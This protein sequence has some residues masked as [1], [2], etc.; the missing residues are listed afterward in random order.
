M[1]DG[2]VG[3]QAFDVGLRKRGEVAVEQGENGD[4]DEQDAHLRQHEERL[5][6]TE[7]HDEAGRFRA[8]GEKCGDRGRCALVHISDPNVKWDGGDFEAERDQDQHGAEERG[9]FFQIRTAECRA[10]PLQVGFAGRAKNPG[11]AVNEKAGRERA[12]HEVFHAGF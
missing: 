8:D 9:C 6:H 10:D 7:E 2:G 12:E 5:E 1:R 3:K 4:G 11:D